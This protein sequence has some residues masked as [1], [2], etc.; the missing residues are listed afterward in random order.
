LGAPANGSAAAIA[1]N[2]GHPQFMISIKQ[3]GSIQ[4]VISRYFKLE[5]EFCKS[6]VRK[7]IS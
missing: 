3:R 1:S 4:D 7:R 5:L 6:S 2:R